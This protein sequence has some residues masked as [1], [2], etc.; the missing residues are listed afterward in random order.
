MA[1]ASRRGLRSPIFPD[2]TFEFVPIKEHRNFVNCARIPR[3]CDLPTYTRRADSL[4][5]Y[6]PKSVALYRAH[7]DPEFNTFTYGDIV[8]S[9]S[10]NLRDATKGDQLWFLARLWNYDEAGW[11]QGSNFY[12]IGLFEVESN[13]F[14][15]E[16]TEPES[17]SADVRQRIQA[18]A[19]YKRWAGA[20]DRSA[21][22]VITGRRPGSFRFDR[23]L[24]VTPEVAAHLFGG[25]YDPHERLFRL[26]DEILTN[27][28][29]CPRRVETFGSATR[30]IQA[31]LD[32]AVA[33]HQEHL[34]W[35]SRLAA[36]HA[37]S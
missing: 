3:Y 28:N 23:G 24:Q 25:R 31:F 6:V 30:T 36:T 32:S 2:G 19:H 22:R 13:I 12:F 27:R 14:V 7:L 17:F 4:A 33:G 20:G 21:F 26:G 37:G 15:E 5:A 1:D 29:G 34:T 9:R 35:L 8:S 10:A 18:N 11:A 16:E